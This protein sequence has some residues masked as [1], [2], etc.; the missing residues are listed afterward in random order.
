MPELKQYRTDAV[1]FLTQER[2]AVEF[3]RGIVEQAEADGWIVA[4]DEIIAPYVWNSGKQD[5]KLSNIM[6]QIPEWT[7]D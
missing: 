3:V 6:D 2:K 1:S 5:T 4:R 7:D